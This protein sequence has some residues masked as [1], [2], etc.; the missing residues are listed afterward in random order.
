MKK[1]N[2]LTVTQVA[3]ELSLSRQTI[4]NYMAQGYIE[5]DRRIVT[6]TGYTRYLFEAEKIAHLQN[7]MIEIA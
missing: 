1:T 3:R 4:Y 6:P 2:L 5:P 7:I